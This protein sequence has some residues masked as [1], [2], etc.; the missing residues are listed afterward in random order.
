[1]KTT[2]LLVL[3]T[4]WVGTALAR[5]PV[6][7]TFPPHPGGRVELRHITAGPLTAVEI[8]PVL[9][10]LPARLRRCAVA[11]W[12]R[13]PDVGFTASGHD[14]VLEVAADGRARATDLDAAPDSSAQERAW[15]ACGRRVVNQLRFPTKDAPSTL[16]VSLIWM[17]DDIPHGSGLL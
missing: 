17:R 16:R 14:F 6:T 8:G 13:E 2:T 11:R 10:R 4:L 12:R 7:E 1:M 15:L 3:S 5:P 9:A